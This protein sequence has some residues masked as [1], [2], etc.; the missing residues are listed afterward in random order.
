MHTDKGHGSFLLEPRLYTP[1]L[2]HVLDTEPA[3]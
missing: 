3:R 2:Q 1:H